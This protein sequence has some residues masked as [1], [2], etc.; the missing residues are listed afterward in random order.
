MADYSLQI[1]QTFQA[2]FTFPSAPH[3]QPLSLSTF[4]ALNNITLTWL[5]TLTHSLTH[6]DF[7]FFTMRSSYSGKGWNWI[8]MKMNNV[9]LRNCS[10]QNSHTMLTE[11]ILK[12]TFWFKPRLLQIQSCWSSKWIQIHIV[13]MSFLLVRVDFACITVR[14]KHCRIYIHRFSPI[15]MKNAFITTGDSKWPLFTGSMQTMSPFSLVF[16]YF[17]P[18]SS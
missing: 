5:V 8:D 2:L 7:V 14:M 12:N 3:G 13:A 4:L 15:R 1:W 6:S 9:E 18:F 11:I 17:H 10:S 16:H